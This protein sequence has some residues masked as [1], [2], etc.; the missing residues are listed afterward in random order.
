[1]AKKAAMAGAAAHSRRAATAPIATLNQNTVD[2]SVVIDVLP[3][4]QRRRET[5][6]TNTPAMPV[7]RDE[8]RDGAELLRADEPREDDRDRKRQA[9][10]EQRVRATPERGREGPLLQHR[11]ALE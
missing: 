10:P 4:D 6:F 1:M 9:L 7:N 8:E 11:I 5:A 2:S 3:L